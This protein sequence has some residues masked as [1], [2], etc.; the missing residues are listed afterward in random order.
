MLILHVLDNAHGHVV[1][2]HGTS[3]SSVYR[4]VMIAWLVSVLGAAALMGT[5]LL[6][7]RQNREAQ[8]RRETDNVT[9]VLEEHAQSLIEQVDQ[10]LIDVRDYLAETAGAP[11][12]NPAG[13]TAEMRRMLRRRIA[14]VPEAEV[15]HVANADGAYIYSSLGEVPAINISDR[16]FF[17]EHQ[18]NASSGLVFSQP[19]MSRTLGVWVITL[20]RRIDAP[21][22]TIAGVVNV[23]VPLQNIAAFYASLDMGPHGA[24]LM[25][26]SEMRLI[27]R[28]PAL[29]ANMGVAMRD[30]PLA[31]FQQQG[32]RNGV[33]VEQ[34]PADGIKRV[35]SFRRVGE[36]PLYVLAAL[37][38][39]DYLAEWWMHVYWYGAAGAGIVVA[40][41]VLAL[42]ARQRMIRQQRA[43]DELADYRE[44]L[45]QL[46]SERTRELQE[47][48]RLAEAA[49]VAK[50]G[51]LANMSHEIRTPMNAILG[52][53]KIVLD[54]P[55]DERQRDY[56][57]K[58][59]D[60]SRALLGILN[61]ILDYSKTESGRI[62]IEAVDFS[63]EKTLRTTADLFS[64]QIDQ[65]GIELFIDIAR[66]VPDALVG[67]PLRLAQVINN[68]VGNAV[69]FTE[70]GEIHVRVDVDPVVA[71]A[72]EAGHETPDGSA[73]AR[74]EGEGALLLRF[75]VRDTGIG[76]PAERIETLFQPFV[77]ADASVTRR[78]GGTGLGL[79]LA[80]RL[81][82][83][84]G[85]RISVTSEV[86]MGSCFVFS[87]G[88]RRARSQAALSSRRG[89]GL[90]AIS[91]LRV[92]IVDDQETSLAILRDVLERWGFDVVCAHSGDECLEEF[93]AARA[94]G[95]DFGLL[96]IDWKMPG[97]NGL[98]TLDAIAALRTG[99]SEPPLAVVMV[100]AYSR[101]EL[102]RAQ[103]GV[104]P[105]AILTKPVT[106]SVLY[107]ALVQLPAVRAQAGALPSAAPGGCSPPTMP[108]LVGA[109]LLLVE[110][111]AVNQLVARAYL[112]REGALV[113]AA[114]NGVQALERVEGERFD[115]VLMDLHMPLMDGLEATRRLRARAASRDLPIIAMTAAAMPKD[116]EDCLAVGM[117]GYVAKP[118]NPDD[119][120]GELQKWLR[121]GALSAPVQPADAAIPAAVSAGQ[122]EPPA[123][124]E[125]LER[126]LPGIS[127][128]AAL[129][130]LRGNTG[131]YR[132][133]LQV[134][135]QQLRTAAERI[136]AALANGDGAALYRE[137]HDLKGVCGNLGVD[138]VAQAGERL[139]SHVKAG[140]AND[141]AGTIGAIADGREGEL[142]PL[143]Q[144]LAE[145]CDA[146][147][148]TLEV[149]GE[150]P[151]PGNPP[152]A[153]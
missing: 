95:R 114:D 143:A 89:E 90:Q 71:P 74:A 47:A 30:H 78:F 149:L 35:Y 121:P 64:A 27:A 60:A 116:R 105:D 13:R 63:L 4:L 29:D 11:A 145:H 57:S 41:L 84:M 108:R 21:D 119:L 18:V 142:V 66:D 14:T 6:Q 61:D 67:D 68:L 107:D 138:A 97:M 101:D 45:E 134:H 144:A 130:R 1:M 135:A 85:G 3:R 19:L 22:G 46:V 2:A 128:R 32:I 92:L 148:R 111:N 73:D 36:L 122:G 140:H 56:L 69:K 48:R 51:F 80:K 44:H 137:A 55:L 99:E 91:A 24:V 131:L 93:R 110:D 16:A 100:T 23:I 102:L 129:A 147:V 65:R 7:E 109:R 141:S 115:A 34:S 8:A 139:V 151:V 94:Q 49:S 133:L 112:E 76:I 96:I 113:S 28:F 39:R 136:R 117:N 37:A 88:L 124:A 59:H 62:D 79:A 106:P 54:T 146:A 9:R 132:R 123:E 50:S 31:R 72:V 5:S 120:I 17:I 153:S 58:V 33:Y 81:V 20:S 150:A 126:A 152:P 77:Q 87:V 53:T 25:R 70:H 103:R 26:D 40:S 10:V 104:A 52:L 75:C 86:G 83:L 82:E 127:V 118:I 42:F 15:V 38:E 43:E 98:D 125:T 12:A